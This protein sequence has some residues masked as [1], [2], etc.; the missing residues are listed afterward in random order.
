NIGNGNVVVTPVAGAPGSFLIEAAG[1]L[2][3][4][5]GL[6]VLSGP[7]TLTISVKSTVS[8]S[9]ANTPVATSDTLVNGGPGDDHVESNINAPVA[10]D[11]GS[12][13]DTVV[14]IGTEANDNFAIT[15]DSVMGAGVNVKFENL[16]KVEVDGLGGNDN[17]W[18]LSTA[19]GVLT[20]LEGGQGSDTF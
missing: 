18:V 3:S 12:G 9:A 13:F 1:T 6:G 4:L 17:F 7:A 11:G 8:S 15:Q 10:L 2:N 16:E 20:I 19:P 5:P 14:V